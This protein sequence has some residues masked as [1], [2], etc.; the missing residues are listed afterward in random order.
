MLTPLELKYNI[1][2]LR[3]TK[4]EPRKFIF[5]KVRGSVRKVFVDDLKSI[6]MR[7]KPTNRPKVP[8][9]D[10]MPKVI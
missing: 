9:F 10:A 2:S 4:Q 7:K 1:K 5:A 6:I 3:M 8:A